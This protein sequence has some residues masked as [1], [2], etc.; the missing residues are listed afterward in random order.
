MCTLCF[1]EI[2][3]GLQIDEGGVNKEPPTMAQVISDGS[4][5]IIAGSDTTATVLSNLFYFLMTNHEAYK[6]LQ[7]EVDKFYPEDEDPFATKHHEE[8]SYLTACM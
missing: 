6:R 3:N 2:N 5:A 1:S 7:A 4:F 8:M